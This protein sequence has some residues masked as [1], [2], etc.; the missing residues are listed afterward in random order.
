MGGDQFTPRETST[1]EKH[2]G[3]GNTMGP[4]SP[5]KIQEQTTGHSITQV[6]HRKKGQVISDNNLSNPVSIE[7]VEQERGPQ[8]D[9]MPYTSD[10]LPIAKW[11]GTR[12]CVRYYKFL[13]HRGYTSVHPLDKVV[14]YNRL[15]SAFRSFNV[16]LDTQIIPN[17]IKE[18][19]DHPGWKQAVNDEMSALVKN[20]TWLLVTKPDNISPVGYKWVFL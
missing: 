11:K 12:E 13:S 1:V 9:I 4:E 20:D 16:N 6:Y 5:T 19:L 17:S 10:P 7:S 8:S 18:A 14:S 15:N 3:E 2:P